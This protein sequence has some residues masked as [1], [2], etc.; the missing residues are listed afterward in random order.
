MNDEIRNLSLTT[1]NYRRSR[2]AQGL[3]KNKKGRNL[4]EASNMLQMVLTMTATWKL[5]LWHLRKRCSV[6][7]DPTLSSGVQENHYL[8][9]KDQARTK[10]QALIAG[11]KQWWSQI[12]VTGGVGRGVTF[13]LFNVGKPTEW[14]TRMAW[15]TTQHLG[16]AVTSCGNSHWSVVC[17]YKP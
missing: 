12:R 6:K 5:L 9:R 16:C 15:A 10:E 3:V 2:L 7:Q 11:V 14:F 1:H 17:H 4:P 13:T 8:V